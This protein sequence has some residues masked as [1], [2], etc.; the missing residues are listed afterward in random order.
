MQSKA[1]RKIQDMVYPVAN[2]C[3]NKYSKETD[4]T[5][6]AM[7][8]F[9]RIFTRKGF[10]FDPETQL[11]IATEDLGEEMGQRIRELHTL[12]QSSSDTE[13]AEIKDIALTCFHEK[14]DYEFD[15]EPESTDYSVSYDAD[16]G[17]VQGV[18]AKTQDFEISYYTPAPPTVRVTPPLVLHAYDTAMRTVVGRQLDGEG[19]SWRDFQDDII[20]GVTLIP[21][22][23]KIGSRR[24]DLAPLLQ[25]RGIEIDAV[26]T[27]VSEGN[28]VL[29]NGQHYFDAEDIVNSDKQ[30]K[31]PGF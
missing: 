28:R 25:A 18:Q 27:M 2:A 4:N 8:I 17:R 23:V 20:T 3:A 6:Q 7:L 29:V 11:A 31:K 9:D 15:Y 5:F 16:V 13:K 30:S 12:Y 19:A 10:R 22:Q 26:R 14:F 1:K 24:I 21:P